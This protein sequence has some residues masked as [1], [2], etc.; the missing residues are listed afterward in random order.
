MNRDIQL[1]FEKY[2]TS[3]SEETLSTGNM[4][5]DQLKDYL[6]TIKSATPV[7]VEVESL[8]PMIKTGNP[9][10]G[11]IKFSKIS[12]VAGGDYQ[13]GVMNREIT[14]NTDP[15]ADINEPA[16]D[17]KFE[18]GSLWNGKG[19]RITPLVIRHVDTGELYLAIGS[20]QSGSSAYMFKGQPIEKEKITPWLKKQAEQ[21]VKQGEVGIP[22]EKQ[23]KPRYPMLKNIKKIRINNVELNIK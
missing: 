20:A 2:V 21:S 10:L 18:A 15:D 14:A 17:P 6:M 4:S 3:I 16:Y 22:V 7:Y 8:A 9:Y 19:K 23:L 13:I 5:V 11:T 1:I 12:G